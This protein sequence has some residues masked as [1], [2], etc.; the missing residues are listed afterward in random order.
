VKRIVIR[1]VAAAD[2]DDAFHWYEDQRP[3]LGEEF[4]DV[5]R[6]TLDKIC[7]YPRLY[8]LLYRNTRRAIMPR[9]PYGN[10][11]REYSD[12]SVIVACMHGRRDPRR[13]QARE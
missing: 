5:L 3:G 12:V 10:Y 2:I 6:V 4:R 9:F 7:E 1:P 11:Y 8:Q 13:W